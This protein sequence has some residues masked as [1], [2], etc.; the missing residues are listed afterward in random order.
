MHD[1]SDR[2]LTA[3]NDPEGTV[4]DGIVRIV[5]ARDESKERRDSRNTSPG[6]HVTASS[7]TESQS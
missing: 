2:S 6:V 4:R 5:L 1:E 3:N 7:N